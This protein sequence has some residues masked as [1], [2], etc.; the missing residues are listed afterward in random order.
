[1]TTKI[2]S[3]QA[4]T[5]DIVNKITTGSTKSNVDDDQQPNS[6][7]KASSA[8]VSDSTNTFSRSAAQNDVAAA[9]ARVKAKREAKLAAADIKRRES[10]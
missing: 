4:K 5:R 7:S 10:E 1:M 2:L 9:V 6:D 3:R 8:T